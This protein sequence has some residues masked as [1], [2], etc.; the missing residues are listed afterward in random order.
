MKDHEKEFEVLEASIVHSN[1]PKFMIESQQLIEKFWDLPETLFELYS[2]RYN[3]IQDTALLSFI[4]SE[5]LRISM[6]YFHNLEGVEVVVSDGHEDM[7]KNIKKVSLLTEKYQENYIKDLIEVSKTF[8]KMYLHDFLNE[9]HKEAYANSSI[10]SQGGEVI[11]QDKQNLVQMYSAQRGNLRTSRRVMNGNLDEFSCISLDH[12]SNDFDL[13]MLE[14]KS[15]QVN[16]LVESQ[17][18]NSQYAGAFLNN[19]CYKH[20]TESTEDIA[21]GNTAEE[22]IKTCCEEL[23]FKRI[24]INSVSMKR[25]QGN[26]MKFFMEGTQSQRINFFKNHE[27]SK[28]QK[29][30]LVFEDIDSVFADEAGFSSGVVRCLESSKIPIILTSHKH[31]KDSEITKRCEKK[32]FNIK[33]I[34]VTKNDVSAMKVKIRMHIIILF[35][36]IINKH[37]KE[38]L[39]ANE[40]D[41]SRGN[42]FNLEALPIWDEELS[43]DQISN[44]YTYITILLKYMNF[45][46]KKILALIGTYSWEDITASIDS[47]KLSPLKF[48]SRK[49]I[50]FTDE[51]FSTHNPGLTMT[52]NIFSKILPDICQNDKSKKHEWSSTEESSKVESWTA[53]PSKLVDEN[54]CLE[55]YQTYIQNLSDFCHVQTRQEEFHENIKSKNIWDVN[56]TKIEDCHKN[57]MREV[58]DEFFMG[59]SFPRQKIERPPSVKKTRGQNSDVFERFLKTDYYNNSFPRMTMDV[60]SEK[61]A[62]VPYYCYISKDGN[63]RRDKTKL[64]WIDS[65]YGSLDES[66]TFHDLNTKLLYSK[67]YK[68]CE[69]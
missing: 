51:L 21:V 68:T 44:H 23:G 6:I 36:W 7:K 14:P 13:A 15:A 43:Y 50:L 11:D 46:L 63:L 9:D 28:K 8:L 10:Q 67:V 64:N 26:L 34:E 33:N 61:K 56:I 3:K 66:M 41:D 55:A 40:N 53:S 58:V 22:V 30:V 57:G 2:S 54:D 27:E 19:E 37:V 59:K 52:T 60:A 32:Q 45:N 4:K 31:F 25:T 48:T 16:S 62:N 5:V 17:K 47:S 29:T 49:D 65:L 42:E 69:Q 38:Y 24:L 18:D 39:Q 1:R 35:E 12:E 20:Q